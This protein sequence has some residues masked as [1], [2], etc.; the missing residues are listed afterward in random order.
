MK[1][2]LPQTSVGMANALKD[3]CLIHRLPPNLAYMLPPKY[4]FTG[5][6]AAYA[7][8]VEVSIEPKQNSN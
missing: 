4:P 1:N 5:A 7:N 3:I 2:A 6:V 8:I